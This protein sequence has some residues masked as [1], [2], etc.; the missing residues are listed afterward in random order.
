LIERYLDI[1]KV[2]TYDLPFWLVFLRCMFVCKSKTNW[3]FKLKLSMLGP[4]STLH[5]TGN[6][7]SG[8]LDVSMPR[9]SGVCI[10]APD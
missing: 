9:P 5:G 7:S 1:Y 10:C 3:I 8:C 4:N 2:D 6:R